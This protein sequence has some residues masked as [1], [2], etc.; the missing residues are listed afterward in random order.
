MERLAPVKASNPDA[1]WDAW[2]QTAYEQKINLSAQG[3]YSL[4]KESRM[5]WETGRGEPAH[6]YA[7]GASCSE[8]EIDCRPVR[9]ILKRGV[10]G[11]PNVK[12]TP[13]FNDHALNNRILITR[14]ARLFHSKTYYLHL[15]HDS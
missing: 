9:R 7:Y 6:Y 13:T 4:P 10:T 8:V 14:Q 5:N 3:F 12:T 1:G 15:V 11:D 2:V